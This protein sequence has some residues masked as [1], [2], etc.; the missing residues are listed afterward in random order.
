LISALGNGNPI[1]SIPYFLGGGVAVATSITGYGSDQIISARMIDAKGNIVEVTEEKEP[2]LL[3]ALRGA[4]Q[5]FG[6]V[7]EL[8]IKAHPFAALGN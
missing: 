5:F 7:T 4:G 8:V 1:G 2:D 6:L 3:F